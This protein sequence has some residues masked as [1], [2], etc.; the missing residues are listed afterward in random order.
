[1]LYFRILATAGASN[2]LL[3]TLL[4]PVTGVLLGVLVL[5]ERLAPEHG[6]GM[7]AIALGLAAIDGRLLAVFSPRASPL[8][9][10]R[11]R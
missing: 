7:V 11:R 4:I 5:D 8:T 10:G 2:L 1:M 3:V 6:L 9:P